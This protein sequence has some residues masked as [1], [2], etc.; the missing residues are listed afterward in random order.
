[1][2]VGS[3]EVKVRDDCNFSKF[4]VMGTPIRVGAF[5]HVEVEP[6]Y[7]LN[8]WYFNLPMPSA[9]GPDQVETFTFL[10]NDSDLVCYTF[11]N[12]S[13]NYV[14]SFSTTYFHAQS[15]P[16]NYKY[17]P[18]SYQFTLSCQRLCGAGFLIPSQAPNP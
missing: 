9:P 10:S 14:S 1:M 8:T 12:G 5:P 17:Q 3:L 6:S 15:L 16:Q 18:Q 2:Q 11:I 4:K 7:A 13:I